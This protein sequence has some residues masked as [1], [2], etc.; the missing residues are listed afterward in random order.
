MRPSVRELHVVPV[1]DDVPA[2]VGELA[3]PGDLVI[4]LGAG[5]IS[6][7]GERVLSAIGRT[8]E[9]RADHHILYRIIRPDFEQRWVE[10]HGRLLCD[11]AG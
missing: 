10:A 5:S 11:P 1:L 7:V 4:T 6:T 3:R 9:E 8:V 2:A